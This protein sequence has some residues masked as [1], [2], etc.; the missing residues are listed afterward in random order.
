MKN[1]PIMNAIIFLVLF[2]IGCVAL[3]IGIPKYEKYEC[4]KWSEQSNNYSNW[5][6][7]DWQKQQCQEYG[8][9]LK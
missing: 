9:Q 5:Y 2:V 8:I 3:G 7:T 1:E 4:L 6:S